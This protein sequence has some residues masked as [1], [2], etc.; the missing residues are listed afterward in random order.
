MSSSD[1]KV[2][3][4]RIH[5]RVEGQGDPVVL[6]HGLGGD[7]LSWR[8]PVLEMLRRRHMVISMDL[9][10]HGR[11]TAGKATYTTKLF[12]A[13]VAMLLEHLN[14]AAASVVGISMGGAVA[15]LLA[16]RCPGLVGRLVLVNTWSRCDASACACFDEWIA[17]SKV[18]RRLLQDLV[19]L[20]TATPQFVAAHPAF[21]RTF[22]RLWPT[23][24]GA[25]FRRSCTACTSHDATARLGRIKAPTLVVA[26]D[27]D[28]LVPPPHARQVAAGIGGAKL[29]VIGGAGHVPWLDR[30]ARTV[31][32]LRAFLR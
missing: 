17:A 2:D 30:P 32:E 20:R 10:G 12:A 31:R 21:V 24:H 25:N 15:M 13:D 7:H 22:R 9:R 6:V 11:S 1:I 14:V 8:G 29:S 19:L 23:N 3:G 26:G 4:V 27:R 18:S 28:L 5:F 16:A